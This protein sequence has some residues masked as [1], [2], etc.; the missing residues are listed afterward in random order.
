VPDG[1]KAVQGISA[2]WFLAKQSNKHQDTVKALEEA[3][4]SGNMTAFSQVLLIRSAE[5]AKAIDDV[6]TGSYS[7][8]DKQKML[9]PLQDEKD[10]AD[11][12]Y[13]GLQQLR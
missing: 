3:R 11:S 8:A 13:A 7:I 4:D 6:T 5:L 2:E 1:S 12:S 10:W 9:K